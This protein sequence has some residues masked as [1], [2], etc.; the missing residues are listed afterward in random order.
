[1]RTHAGPVGCVAVPG[2]GLSV[3]G[4]EP[5]LTRLDLPRA[6][7][8]V[9]LPAYG[10]PAPWGSALDPR[11][12]AERLIRHLDELEV[13]RAVL[14]GHSAACQ[15]V[16]EAG[17][18]A[19][20]RV[21]ALVLVGPTGDPVARPWA[22]LVR[23]WLDNLPGE[24]PRLVPLLLRDYTYSGMV[25]FA[26]AMDAARRHRLDETVAA[27]RCPLLLVRGARDHISP[28]AFLDRL[29]ACAGHARVATV[30]GAAHMAPLTH[31]RELAAAV[32][33]FV[34]GR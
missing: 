32:R 12:T 34:T 13:G 23:R 14:F 5:A 26:R 18:S 6:A 28:P 22:T 2:L 16:A 21:A 33:P 11:A 3:R 15:V 27:L 9:A 7:V 24:S 31:P 25:S 17:R 19:P 4:W 29:A 10:L 30:P 20:D 1:M 8:A